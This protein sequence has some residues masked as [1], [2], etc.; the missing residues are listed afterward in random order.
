MGYTMYTYPNLNQKTVKV[1]YSGAASLVRAGK[2]GIDDA[3]RNWSGMSGREQWN[4]SK[5]S[6][7]HLDST[8]IAS[9]KINSSFMTDK[10]TNPQE[11]KLMEINMLD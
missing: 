7:T 2:W 5:E 11:C 6:L 10:P 9:W 4:L 8:G 1:P 3:V